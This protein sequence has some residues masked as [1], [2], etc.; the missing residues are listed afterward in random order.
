LAETLSNRTARV[1]IN[2]PAVRYFE[3]ELN[4]K[5][6]VTNFL[7]RD[8]DEAFVRNFRWRWPSYESYVPG[9]LMDSSGQHF[10]IAGLRNWKPCPWWL[11]PLDWTIGV[12]LVLGPYELDPIL[13]GPEQLTLDDF[14]ERLCKLVGR[15]RGLH[16]GGHVGYRG[17]QKL[18][19][20]APDYERCIFA[21]YDKAMY[22]DERI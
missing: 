1:K 9:G 13:E 8:W 3:P 11:K 16:T 21:I 10:V 4:A 20:A 22:S 17:M 19:R 15:E 2:F 5:P 6:A 14:K 7:V 18:I 12:F